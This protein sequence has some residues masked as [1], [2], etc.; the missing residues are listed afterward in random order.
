[1]IPEFLKVRNSCNTPAF[2]M[3]TPFPGD[4]EEKVKVI[5]DIRSG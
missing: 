2:Y 4:E 5:F 3:H 1:M